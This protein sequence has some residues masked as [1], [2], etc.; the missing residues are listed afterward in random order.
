LKEEALDCTL[1]SAH[2]GRG[3]GPVIRQTTRMNVYCTAKLL[4]SNP[5]CSCSGNL[6]NIWSSDITCQLVA[7]CQLQHGSVTGLTMLKYMYD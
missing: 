3:F 4:P 1:W 5:L 6:K 7:A 2:F